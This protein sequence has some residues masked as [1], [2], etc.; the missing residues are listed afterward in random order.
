MKR[1]HSVLLSLVL[2][3]G[4][5][6]AWYALRPAPQPPEKVATATVKRGTVAKRV[7]AVGHIEPVNQVSI[8]SNVSGDL[9]RLSVHDG[10]Y[11]H[12]GDVLARVRADQWEAVVRQ[13][14]ANMKSMAAQVDLEVANLAQA[15]AELARQE[16]LFQQRLAAATDLERAQVNLSVTQARLD[17]ARQKVLQAQGALEEA[18]TR[19]AQT[20]IYAPI[21]GT[22][23]DLKKK[24][25]ERIRGSDLGDDPLLTLAPLEAM[26]VK[27]EVT[28][29]DVVGVRLQQKA[30]ITVDSLDR[31]AIPGHVLE[32]ANSAII[33]NAGTEAETT[34]FVVKVAL[35]EV[36]PNLRSG[37]SA[38]VAI[39]TE[40]HDGVLAIPLEAV[41]ARLPSQL[42]E[43]ADTVQAKKKKSIFGGGEDPA[44]DPSLR[45][46][47]RERPVEVVFTVT[48][49]KAEPH[50]VK[51]GISSE[52]EI[53]IVDGLEP[54]QEVI[55]GP[56]KL[57]SR[58]L[59][60]GAPV[61]VIHAKEAP[62]T[63]S[64]AL[65][66]RVGP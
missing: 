39:L 57:L 47:K 3:G 5:A 41:T 11:L 60:P 15:K 9:V 16:A 51:T 6:A 38:A 37:M 21:E 28:E 52:S 61:D 64:D 32:I 19:L 20:T 50:R 23:I 7:K 46:G 55:V 54:D 1:A 25:G 59:V 42:E 40:T 44:D 10:D 12:K 53:E 30:D 58:T 22:V 4:G 65:A 29:Q 63:G 24:L 13:N 34:T 49:G 62:K 31:K 26:L 35:D 27:V 56:Y 48:G 43:R 45:I 8:S 14:E 2:A 33:R 18:R 36:P 66:G 17:A